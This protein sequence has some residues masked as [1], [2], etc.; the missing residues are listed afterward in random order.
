[1]KLFTVGTLTTCDV[2]D[3]KYFRSPVSKVKEA[4]NAVNGKY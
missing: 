3:F 4:Q 2:A 1:M